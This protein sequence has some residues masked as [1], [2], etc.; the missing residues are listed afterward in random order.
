M[1]Q[2]TQAYL[3]THVPVPPEKPTLPIG[4]FQQLLSPPPPHHISGQLHIDVKP[5]GSSDLALGLYDQSSGSPLTHYP[6]AL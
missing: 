4:D 1:S 6:T 5:K 3:P 2:V